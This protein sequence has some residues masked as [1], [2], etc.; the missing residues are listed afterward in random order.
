MKQARLIFPVK[1]AAVVAK[2]FAEQGVV[3][4]LSYVTTDGFFTAQIICIVCF[5]EDKEDNFKAN[6]HKYIQA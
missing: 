2:Y 6:M 1:Q 4:N 3:T 5:A